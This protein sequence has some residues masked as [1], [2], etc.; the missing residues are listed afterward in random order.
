MRTFYLREYDEDLDDSV[1]VAEGVEF[2]DRRCVMTW[3]T[4]NQSMVIHKNI[5]EL[6]KV[7][8]SGSPSWTVLVWN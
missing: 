2:T 5:F 7:H 4:G 8:T 3:L 1:V 6:I